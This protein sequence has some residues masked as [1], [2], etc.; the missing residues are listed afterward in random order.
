MPSGGKKRIR[1]RDDSEHIYI[2]PDTNK[3]SRYCMS[4]IQLSFFLNL[5]IKNKFNKT[6]TE[7]YLGQWAS[8]KK[9]SRERER[10]QHGGRGGAE[11]SV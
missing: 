1:A 6:S 3:D 5:K 8:E 4:E 2:K 7:I 10:E 9:D 11:T